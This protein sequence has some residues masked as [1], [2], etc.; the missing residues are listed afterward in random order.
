MVVAGVSIAADCKFV[1]FWQRESFLAEGME[2]LIKTDASLMGR[3]CQTKRG[4]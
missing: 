4:L 2:T 1:W 3:S